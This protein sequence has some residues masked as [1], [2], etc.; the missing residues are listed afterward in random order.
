MKS[1]SKSLSAHFITW[2]ISQKCYEIS[3]VKYFMK[4]WGRTYTKPFSA[5]CSFKGH[6]CLNL[7]LKAADLFKY[8]DIKH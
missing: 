8:V 4:A 6:A 3:F 5:W 7:H 1:F 2:S